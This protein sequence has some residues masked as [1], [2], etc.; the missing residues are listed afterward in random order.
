MYYTKVQKNYLGNQGVNKK[1]RGRIEKK[2]CGGTLSV[3]NILT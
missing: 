3:Q 1:G 2:G